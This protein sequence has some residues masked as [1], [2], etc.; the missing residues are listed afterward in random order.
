MQMQCSGLS[1]QFWMAGKM[2]RRQTRQTKM[3]DSRQIDDTCG[4]Q[5]SGSLTWPR[6]TYV[7]T[8]L[9][10][11]KKLPRQPMSIRCNWPQAVCSTLFLY[12]SLSLFSILVLH[13]SR[14]H[15]ASN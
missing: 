1:E 4:Q 9:A 10:N 6:S 8:P 13:V 5:G 15:T 14:I 12:S 2:V 3:A 11:E 7:S